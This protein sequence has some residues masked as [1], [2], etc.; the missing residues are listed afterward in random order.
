MFCGNFTS[1]MDGNRVPIP[2]EFRKV[3]RGRRV[4]I[5]IFPEGCL[6]LCPRK[7]WKRGIRELEKEALLGT[8]E[9][10]EE[11]R[12]ILSKAEEVNIDESGKILIPD[13]LRKYA[14]LQK[15]VVFVGCGNRVEIWNAKR[16]EMEQLKWLDILKDEYEEG[17]I[18]PLRVSSN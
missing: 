16:W 4:I 5:S 1:R 9:M 10:R 13:E 8:I 7:K 3:L 14:N 17:I 18:V 11:S 2:L 12:I 6:F 15:E